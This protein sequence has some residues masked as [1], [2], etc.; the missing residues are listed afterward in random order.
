[1]ERLTPNEIARLLGTATPQ[2]L[3]DID[4]VIDQCLAIAED[5]FPLPSGRSYERPTVAFNLKGTTAGQAWRAKIKLNSELLHNSELYPEMINQTLPH[6][7]AHCVVIQKW[8]HAAQS[9]GY[10]WKTVMRA[11][12]LIPHRTH[13]MPAKKA[14]KHPRPHVY[15]C[16]CRVY[17]LTNR[18]HNSILSGR[19][20]Y[21][22]ECGQWLTYQYNAGIQD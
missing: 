7:I 10:E 2:Q 1:M 13:S 22:R 3:K 16:A 19:R 9:H 15:Q 18:M 12:G 17:K 21:C 8:G 5:K 11:F 14:R 20:R 6:E 4:S